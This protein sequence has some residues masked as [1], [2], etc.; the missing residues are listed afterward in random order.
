M[1]TVVVPDAR[2]VLAEPY[3]SPLPSRLEEL[4]R[5]G[6]EILEQAAASLPDG[7]ALE[8]VARKGPPGPAIVEQ[9][10]EGGHDLVVVGSRGFGAI[11]SLVLG[12]VSRH[13]LEHSPVSVLIVR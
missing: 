3:A 5:E 7:V 8:A 2:P 11:K 10:E 12:S 9:I 4:E 13:V 1:L 6:A